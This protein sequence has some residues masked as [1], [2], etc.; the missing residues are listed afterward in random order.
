M[1]LGGGGMRKISVRIGSKKTNPSQEKKLFEECEFPY[2]LSNLRTKKS[3]AFCFQFRTV[4]CSVLGELGMTL[5]KS[6]GKTN[7]SQSPR[8]HTAKGHGPAT[9]HQK[10]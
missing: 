8:R 1:H 2:D 5:E 3:L 9:E 10:A 7:P 6:F 4:S